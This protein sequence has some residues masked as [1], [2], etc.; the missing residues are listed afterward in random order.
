MPETHHRNIG[1]G[2]MCGHGSASLGWMTGTFRRSNQQAG[3]RGIEMISASRRQELLKEYAEI[4]RGLDR[5][6]FRMEECSVSTE[7][8]WQ[9]LSVKAIEHMN[10]A[11]AN[12]QWI[13]GEI[14]AVKVDG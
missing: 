12:L 5:L 2:G 1:C 3:K 13:I 14:E 4:H 8:A 11:C 7:P 9:T 10:E 6:A